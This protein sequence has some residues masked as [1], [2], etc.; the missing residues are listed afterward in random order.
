MKLSQPLL[1]V[2][3]VGQLLLAG[4][5]FFQSKSNATVRPD[6]PLL[7]FDIGLIDQLRIEDSENSVKLQRQGD[8]WQL[9][10]SGVPVNSTQ[11]NTLLESLASART[12]WE[13]TTRDESHQQLMV[14]K[15]NF[16]RLVSLYSGDEEV[17]SL[18]VGS[19][20]GLRRS[21]ARVAD[22]VDVYSVALNDY[23]IPAGR[24]DWVQKDVLAMDSIE[25]F[26]FSDYTVSKE[27]DNWKVNSGSDKDIQGD[28][29]AI[30]AFTRQLTNLRILDVA[31]KVPEDAERHTLQVSN[32][33]DQ[34]TYELFSDSDN[35]YVTRSDN[36]NSFILSQSSYSAIVDSDPA[37][38]LP[39]VEADTEIA[40]DQNE[41]MSPA[42][43]G[44]T[45]TENSSSSAKQP[46]QESRITED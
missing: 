39:A 19:S 9:A 34:F 3:L 2:L 25:Q 38:F 31:D 45:Q 1:G 36:D 10:P 23:D 14:A 15:D 16:N 35:H 44:E 28:N 13:V 17:S 37:D 6:D 24:A 18:F 26:S 41:I 4:V 5:L 8:A 11:V 46:V 21:H 27:E 43:A 12:G 7:E 33:D 40:D 29:T 42:D 32:G 22:A 20:P 30:D